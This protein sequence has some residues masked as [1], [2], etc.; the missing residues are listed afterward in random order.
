MRTS[1]SQIVNG[2]SVAQYDSIA[3]ATRLTGADNSNISKVTRG[4]RKTAGGFGWESAESVNSRRKIVA[5]EPTTGETVAVFN[6]LD[7]VRSST[8]VR[9]DRVVD[10]VAGL[11][12]T[13]AG[14]AWSITG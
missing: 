2:K 3:T 5:I 6:S 4:D 12:R 14:L 13:A 7:A 10:A 9:M 1:V 11:R 8:N